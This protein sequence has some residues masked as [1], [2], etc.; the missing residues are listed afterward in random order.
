MP[1]TQVHGYITL[2]I[3]GGLVLASTIWYAA[4]PT[5]LAKPFKGSQEPQ[6]PAPLVEQPI[7]EG[8]YV[9]ANLTT[10]KVELK[11]GTTT[12]ET[13]DIVT[14]GKPGNYYETVGGSYLN[15][16]KVRNHFSSFGHV[17]M[18]WSVHIFGNFFIHGI[19]YYP[20]GTR[21]AST[22][23]GGCI[24]LEDKDAERVYAFVQKGTPIVVIKDSEREFLPTATSTA[25][26]Q[27]IEM[28]RFMVA[29]IS[30]EM[31]MQE[32]QMITDTDGVSLTDR[33]SLLPRLLVKGDDRVSAKLAQAFG[34]KTYLQYMNRR[35]QTLGLTNTTFTSVTQPAT[36]TQEDLERFMDHIK[37]YKS[38]LLSLFPKTN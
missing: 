4:S 7:H 29:V 25:N 26:V 21:V 19:P 8:N 35:V 36:T 33:K 13:F 24:R 6:T 23:S 17:Y 10:M 38:Y 9:V 2:S 1:L 16:Y 12:L 27:S 22:Y 20:D 31:L 3:L 28:T 32:D 14:K 18:P 34:E 5:L 11:N 37:G 15:D 30:L